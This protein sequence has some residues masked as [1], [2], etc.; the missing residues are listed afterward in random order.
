MKNFFAGADYRRRN[1]LAPRLGLPLITLFPSVCLVLPVSPA[2]RL[3]AALAYA[4]QH[5]R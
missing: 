3:L 1:M 4:H 2:T 5:G